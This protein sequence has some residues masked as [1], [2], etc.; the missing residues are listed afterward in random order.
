M[1]RLSLNKAPG[2]DGLTWNFYR[3]F[4]DDIKELIYQVFSETFEF[5]ILPPTMRQGIIISITK[6]DKDQRMI[7]NTRPITLRN[8]D[9]KFTKLSLHF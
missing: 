9:Y 1:E 8:T 6:A 2:L 5:C 4:W 3:N 7:E